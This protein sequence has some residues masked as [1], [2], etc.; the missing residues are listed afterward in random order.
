MTNRE[1]QIGSFPAKVLVVEITGLKKALTL[2]KGIPVPAKTSKG[3][4][5]RIFKTFDGME[6]KPRLQLWEQ[7]MQLNL[8]CRM[9]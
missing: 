6:P 2:S 8:L 7:L 3:F 4:P 9:E 1:K 5:G